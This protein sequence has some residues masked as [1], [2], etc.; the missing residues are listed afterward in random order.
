MRKRNEFICKLITIT[1]LILFVLFWL[2]Y[3]FQNI[4]WYDKIQSLGKLGLV[5][6]LYYVG[7][8]I[9]NIIHLYLFRYFLI[10]LLCGVTNEFIDEWIFDPLNC[11]IFF[12]WLTFLGMLAIS[13]RF[14]KMLI[15]KDIKNYGQSRNNSS[16][17]RVLF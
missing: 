6:M 15:K 9:S 11:N 13:M 1:S 2:S 12:E 7:R 16:S 3:Q 4:E 5:I 17:K 8:Y 14:E 10:L